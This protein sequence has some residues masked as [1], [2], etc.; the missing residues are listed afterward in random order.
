[1]TVAHAADVLAIYASGIRTGNATFE[2]AAPGW[3]DF[4]HQHLAD[5]RFVAVA[6][7][8]SVLGWIAVTPVSDRCVYGGVAEH[9][10]YVRA[11]ARG[12][13]VASALLLELI[14]ST[15]ADG[16]WTLQ[17]GVLAE[18]EASLALHARMG[19]RTVGLRE[20]LGRRDGVWRDVVLVERR[21]TVA[22]V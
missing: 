7:D 18:N 2:A 11:D 4:D 13:G 3:P 20:R 16:I 6:E 17:S 8:G 1:M 22:G 14:R 21:S 15:E 5:H 9:S 10:V 12:H 19:F